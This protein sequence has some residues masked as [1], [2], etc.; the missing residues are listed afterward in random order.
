MSAMPLPPQQPTGPFQWGKGGVRLTPEEIARQRL[1]AQRMGA[2]AM[3]FSPVGHWTQGLA[4]AAQGLMA[5]L[6]ERRIAKAEQ[7]NT[8]E[9]D[10]IMGLLLPQGGGAPAGDDV[11]LRALMSPYASEG[12]REVAKMEWSRR[13]PRPTEPPEAIKLAR[14]ANDP[15]RPE[16]ERKAAAE[17][18]ATKTDPF[19]TIQTRS[20]TFAG[21]RSLVE[22]ALQGG[23]GQASGA[24]QTTAP[25]AEA[26]AELRRDPSGAAEF[27]E[28]FGQGAAARILGEGGGGGRVTSSFLDGL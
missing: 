22:R 18:L 10:E 20:G 21:P 15:T 8:A 16:W 4:R 7:A 13:N 26:I 11:V 27:D 2:G 14:I 24:P 9:N 5:G 19:T 23:G 3:D 25:P 28:V 12:V 1:L 6:D 17:T